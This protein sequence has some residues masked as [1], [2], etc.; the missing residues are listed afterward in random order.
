MVM[1]RDS[2]LDCLNSNP[3]A[4]THQLFH[5]DSSTLCG[6]VLD[7]DNYGDDSITGLPLGSSMEDFME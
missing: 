7:D 1:S 6:A 4:A 2:E 5:L 3:R